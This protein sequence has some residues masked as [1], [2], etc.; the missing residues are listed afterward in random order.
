M[1]KFSIAVIARILANLP[2][3]FNSLKTAWDS[4]LSASQMSEVNRKTDKKRNV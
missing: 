2:L 1:N 3:K 4:V